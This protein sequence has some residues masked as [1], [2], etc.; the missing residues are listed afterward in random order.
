MVWLANN[1]WLIAVLLLSFTLTVLAMHYSRRQ[2][3]YDQPGERR[4]HQIATLRGG[5][6]AILLS[7]VLTQVYLV[8]QKLLTL[9]ISLLFS[10]NLTAIGLIGWWDDHRPL[11]ARYRLIMQILVTSC[12]IV[13]LLYLLVLSGNIVISWTVLALAIVSVISM[14]WLINLL[15]FMDGS[16][17]LAAMQGLFCCVLFAV[18][19]F[20]QGDQT[21]G[22]IA[23]SAAA[24]ILGFLP[25]NWPLKR[26][27]MGDSGSYAIGFT[28]AFLSAYA[29]W[30]SAISVAMIILLQA[31]FLVDSTATLIMRVVQGKRWYTAHR[32]HAYQRLIMMGMSHTKVLMIYTIINIFFILPILGYA[33]SELWNEN[34][35]VALVMIT[36]LVLWLFVQRQWHKNHNNK[37]A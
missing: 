19:L 1:L 6:I 21:G 36:L 24:A 26:V 22:L 8:S 25:W 34:G 16:N 3:L 14:C 10:L 9:D 13:Y 33:Q 5:G 32:E 27:F 7:I 37:N 12:V 17:G 15:N 20:Q 35:L 18:L 29:Y 30:Y 2:G 11:A 28:L 4:S 31:L 23:A